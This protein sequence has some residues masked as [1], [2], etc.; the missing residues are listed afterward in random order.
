MVIISF[1]T[2]YLLLFVYFLDLYFDSRLFLYSVS[3]E[4][5]IGGFFTMLI[6]LIGVTI[7]HI[8]FKEK[9]NKNVLICLFG[10]MS[11][12]LGMA[13]IMFYSLQSLEKIGVCEENPVF[14]YSFPTPDCDDSP[15]F[16]Q[17][18]L[19]GPN[20]KV[21]QLKVSCKDRVRIIDPEY[22]N[23]NCTLYQY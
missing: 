3:L 9:T 11:I 7:Y 20:I 17:K 4:V 18:E 14:Y 22:V 23:S 1:L 19:F 13:F 8:F 10:M 12:F 5:R 16:T 21:D 6:I 15:V 2:Y